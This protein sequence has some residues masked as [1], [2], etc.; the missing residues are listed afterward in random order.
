MAFKPMAPHERASIEA[1]VCLKGGVELACAEIASNPDGVAV[2]S[3]VENAMVLANALSDLKTT[4]AGTEIAIAPSNGDM[5][6]AIAKSS[7]VISEAFEG[8]TQVSTSKP[9]ASK[10]VDDA[11]YAEIHKLFLAESASGI[12][13]GSKDSMFLDNVEIREAF[14][15]GVRTYPADYWME[16]MRGADIPVTKHGKCALGD[17]KVKKGVSINSDGAPILTSGEGNHPLANK[18]GYF[19]GL[20]NHSPFNWADKEKIL[21]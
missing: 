3:A 15:K 1:Q 16:S 20:V 21:A 8:T 6:A 13:Y 12:K 11:D 17:F 18:S 4:L 5:D 14:Q 10:Y 2:T 9:T 7:A 19:A